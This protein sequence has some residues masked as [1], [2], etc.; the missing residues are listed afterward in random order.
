MMGHKSRF[1]LA[2][3]LCFLA[4]SCYRDRYIPIPV[5]QQPKHTPKRLTLDL[6]RGFGVS[7]N[8]L[9]KLRYFLENTLILQKVTR[10]SSAVTT[11]PRRAALDLRREIGQEETVFEHSAPAY[12]AEVWQVIQPQ[13]L[14]RSVYQ[15]AIR[16]E[17]ASDYSLIFSPNWCGDYEL[18]KC[19]ITHSGWSEDVRI[20][21]L[22]PGTDNFLLVDAHLVDNVSHKRQVIPARESTSTT[23][24]EEARP[25]GGS[26]YGI[27][28]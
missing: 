9:L 15:I 7:R 23:R 26:R 28:K 27:G 18:E 2:L 11:A 14:F 12:A 8:D 13:Y 19:Y 4:S 17:E 3:G 6:I 22:I 25:K 16:F 1:G 20:Q 21:S 24:Q 5:Y 10:H